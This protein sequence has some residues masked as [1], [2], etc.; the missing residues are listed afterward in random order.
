MTNIFGV[1][2][3]QSDRYERQEAVTRGLITRVV[4]ERDKSHE[5]ASFHPTAERNH[6]IW[7]VPDR[8]PPSI[9]L[10]TCLRPIGER[11]Q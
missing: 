2:I 6:G 7:V 10:E 8:I 5:E 9:N 3:A 11:T 4:F 1:R